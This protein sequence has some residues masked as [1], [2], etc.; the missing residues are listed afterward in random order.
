GDRFDPKSETFKHYGKS[1]GFLGI[2]NDQN[3]ICKAN[4]GTI[5]FGT[6]NGLIRFDPALDKPNL[7]PPITVI[8]NIE[9]FYS[10]FDY[11]SYADSIDGFS[12]LP[13][14]MRLNYRKNHLT[15]KYVGV[16]HISSERVMYK[17]MLENFDEEWNPVT[18]STS[19]TY[20]NISPPKYF[21]KVLSANN[22][23]KWNENPATVE[24]TILPPFW[25][26]AWFRFLG[27]AFITGFIYG[28][29]W[30]RLRRIK[31]QKSRLEKLVE[32]KT[33][34]LMEEAEE[35]KKAQ[36]KAEEADKLKTAFLANMSHE[37]R[38][39]VNS[40]IGFS[41]LLKET[42][43]DDETRKV[44]L[45]HI[46]NGGSTLLS[47]I[48][49]IIDISRIEAGQLRIANEACNLSGIVRELFPAFFEQL[50]KRNK[51]EVEL[52]ISAGVNGSGPLVYSDPIRLRQIITN[53]LSNSMKFTDSGYI[54]YG[55][56]LKLPGQVKFFVK[57][58]GIGIPVEKQDIIF[59]RF[60]QVEETY[61]R[62]YE[63]T[64]LGLAISKKLVNLMGGDMWMES[65][66]GQGSTFYFTLPYKE[67]E[68]DNSIFVNLTPQMQKDDLT[69]ITIL[70]VEDEIS[71]FHLI[72][73]YMNR[74]HV[75]IIHT[76]EGEDAVEKF[77]IRQQEIGLVLMDIKIQGMDGYEATRE[78]KKISKSVPVVAQTAYAM[79]DEREKCLSAGCDDYISKPYTRQQLFEIIYKNLVVY[80]KLAADNLIQDVADTGEK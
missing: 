25:Q 65:V 39:P 19:A 53:L 69:G 64:G 70:V 27:I 80:N 58:T 73:N 1:D 7:K 35:R 18:N 72:E 44:Y 23:G 60:R 11:S 56:E 54:E 10:D 8:E 24:F 4:D 49:D 13:L 17:Y 2:E 34:E 71:N 26:T 74:W 75:N 31:L 45:T 38:T 36:L 78:I 62:N 50:K 51:S 42:D 67:V 12:G 79:T 41:D 16:S 20:T 57:D 66:P 14:H 15:F 5:W 47:L 33:Q 40:I 43:V 37:I 52:R 46:I 28:L 6:V 30:W 48:N 9:L 3:A 32:S 77:R 21:F 22:D 63:G 59:E 68:F 55:F 61:T 29:F 76:T